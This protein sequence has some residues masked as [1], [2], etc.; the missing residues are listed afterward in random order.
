MGQRKPVGKTGAEVPHAFRHRAGPRGPPLSVGSDQQR[1]SDRGQLFDEP[2]ASP[3]RALGP[4]WRVSAAP[5][6]PRVA[7]SHRQDR[8]PLGVELRRADAHPRAQALARD[9]VERHARDVSLHARRLPRDEDARGGRDLEHRPRPER[10]RRT[11]P[12]GANLVNQPV[13]VGHGEEP[14]ATGGPTRW[15]AMADRSPGT[16]RPAPRRAATRREPTIR[17]TRRGSRRRTPPRSGSSIGCANSCS[18]PGIPPWRDDTITPSAAPPDPG[19]PASARNP[20]S[21]CPLRT[22]RLETIPLPRCE[23]T[24]PRRQG[25]RSRATGPRRAGPRNCWYCIAL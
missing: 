8:D 10:Q 18:P 6:P 4:R 2:R 23:E 5:R 1:Q 17:G 13:E 9:V 21:P 7:E 15:P 12:A 16:S 3:P 24:P 20:E 22:P 25:G 14:D 11:G 19:A